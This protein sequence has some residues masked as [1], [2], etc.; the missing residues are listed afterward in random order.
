MRD[1]GSDSFKD[2]VSI[3]KSF[4]HSLFYPLPYRLTVTGT[5]PV[6]VESEDNRYP[7]QTTTE[8]D[9]KSGCPTLVDPCR[10]PRRPFPR[11]SPRVKY[12]VPV[13]TPFPEV[14]DTVVSLRREVL[15]TL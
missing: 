9:P 7:T 4:V 5:N 14:P 15:S 11:R 6:T 2:D 8:T 12:P 13:E 10:D 3:P 1:G